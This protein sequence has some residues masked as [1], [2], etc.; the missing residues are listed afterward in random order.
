MRRYAIIA[1]LAATLP[2]LS[3]CAPEK[4]AQEKPL[5]HVEVT[6]VKTLEIADTISTTG[7][8]SARVQSDL[9]FRVSGQIVE[10]LVDVGQHVSDGQVL[11]RID[12]QEQKADLQVALATLQSAQAQQT[13]AQQAFDRQQSLFNTGVT[14]RAALDQAQET[15]LTGQG[16]VQSAQ[17]QV[18]TARDALEQTELK[19]DADGIITV[20][21]AEVG[22]VAQAAQLIFTLA[23]DGPRDAV[24]NADET[25]LLGGEIQNDVVVRMISG[26]EPIKATIREVSPTIDTTTGTIRVKLA[27]DPAADVRLGSVVVATA[28]YKPVSTIQLPWS[29]MASS[30]GQ[31]S[32]WIIDPKSNAVSLR[33]I[34]VGTY[35][36]EHFSV[37]SGLSEGETVV[38]DGTKFLSIGEIVAYEGAAQ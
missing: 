24:I 15:L 8:I 7:E 33:K 34:E 37:R 25:T 2:G 20:R 18:D 22:Q 10:R 27:L 36:N 23:H 6:R 26:G 5:R 17:A 13:Q 1:F 30:S 11:A 38:T 12:P 31:P 3:A 28:H 32:V 4:E 16:T 35:V 29:A 19:A 14:T 21:S 9:S